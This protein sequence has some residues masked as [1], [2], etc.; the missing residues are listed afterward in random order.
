MSTVQAVYSVLQ[1]AGY[2]PLI[3]EGPEGAVVFRYFGQ[4]AVFTSREVGLVTI[5]ELECTIPRPAP[6]AE[7]AQEFMQTH[8][9][10]RL[11][12]RGG[13]MLLTLESLLPGSEPGPHV[14]SLLQL[15]DTYAAD[16]AFGVGGHQAAEAELVPAVAAPE[17]VEA[18]AAVT[19]LDVQPAP[20]PLQE[21]QPAPEAP[22][23]ADTAPAAEL[24][25]EWQATRR[26]MHERF[27]PLVE[28]LAELGAPV[29]DEVQMDMMQGQ[30]VRGTAIMMWGT[31]P[32]AV[33]VCEQ[34][35]V[36]PDG[37]RGG[38]WS[39]YQTAQQ[40]AAETLA[41]LQSVRRA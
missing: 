2:R 40:I 21:R 23:P 11:S 7:A 35:Q 6:T 3:G 37:Y 8:P 33:V 30:Q 13:V 32:G 39:K 5:A 1:Q 9:L 16:A 12:G 34:G 17:P 19:P 36:I 22:V 41:H 31:P 25:A 14:L 38:T 27:H 10:S 28:A 18:L 20:E 24:P 15:L 26:L 4:R 29:P